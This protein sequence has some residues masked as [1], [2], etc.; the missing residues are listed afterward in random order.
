MTDQTTLIAV[1]E[2]TQEGLEEIKSELQDL[3]EVK[4]PAIIE[5]VS[6]A[7]E[8]GDLSENSG[9]HLAKAEQELVETKIG[10]LE[11]V[12]SR[13]KVV[14]NT[15]SHVAIG[16]GSTVTVTNQSTNK[17]QTITVVGEYEAN[18]LEGKISTASPLG[19]ALAGKKKGDT[20][21]V[22]APAG[23]IKYK[24]QDIK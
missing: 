14:K 3:K 1:V 2:V 22:K 15:K 18:P 23:E 6:K 13:A 20:V 19:K 10:E 5:R 11:D 17:K 21:I 12:V 7:R 8:D 9:Y 24:I 16:M 4:L